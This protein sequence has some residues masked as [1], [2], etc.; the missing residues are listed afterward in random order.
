MATLRPAPSYQPDVP[1]VSPAGGTAAAY[2]NP[3]SPES[4][5]RKTKELQ[6]QS[7]VDTLYDSS[8]KTHEG[9]CGQSRG[10]PLL[11]SGIAVILLGILAISLRTRNFVRVRR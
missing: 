6:V 10:P 11:L 9:Y 7:Q 8:E 4:I 3:N 2:A 1:V 5:M